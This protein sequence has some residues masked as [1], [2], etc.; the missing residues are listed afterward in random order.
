MTQTPS[1]TTDPFAHLHDENYH[2]AFTLPRCLAKDMITMAGRRTVSLNGEWRFTL[3]LFDEGLRQK[4]F[5]QPPTPIN[6]WRIPRDYDESD[7]QTLSVPSVWSLA[8]PEWTYYEG[9]GWYS[10]TI[11]HSQDHTG[12]RVF[13]RIGAAN[14]ETRIFLNG[15]FLASHQGGST[16]FFVELTEYL[17]N[18]NNRIHLNVDNRRLPERVPMH[19]FDWFNDGG[20]YRDIELVHLPR[21]F[22]RD[23]SLSLV[24]NS[25]LSTFEC[26]VT[27]SDPVDGTAVLSLPALGLQLDIPVKQGRGSIHSAADLRLWSPDDPHLYDCELRF[28][29]D[30]VT[31]RIGFREIKRDG[32][33]LL[34][35]GKPLYLRGV[36]VHEDD[37]VMG[38]VS[39]IADVRRRFEHAKEMGCNTL[40]LAHY[41]H[42]EHTAQLA[43]EMGLLLWEEIPVYWAIQFDNDATYQDARNQLEEMMRRDRNRASV[44]IWGVGNENA[45][46]DARYTFMKNLAQYAKLF[47]PTRLVGAACLINREQFL[48]EDRLADHLDIIGLNE[49]FGWYEEGFEGLRQLLANSTPD[50]PVLISEVGADALAGHHGPTSELFT[51]ERQAWVFENQ[52]EIIRT[53]PWICGFFPWLLY[54]FRSPRRQTSIQNGLNRK[55]LIAEDKTTVKQVF[56]VIAK[57]YGDMRD[58]P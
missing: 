33:T 49:Y 31:D 19:H 51:E 17:L 28:G 11:T 56:D 16:P 10:R 18:G 25:D 54:D 58:K 53:I 27:L 7:A 32:T 47:D 14:Y 57:F 52:I 50:R 9:G 44:I 30:R 3:D 5:A 1:N 34:L 42:H 41:P 4:W 15:H 35:N 45:D 40:R 37:M 39:T 46:T 6:Q 55:G 43:D 12:Q 29:D 20:I 2:A 24:P 48:I 8:K 26:Q 13:L 22:I 23:F 36:C 21:H 38:K